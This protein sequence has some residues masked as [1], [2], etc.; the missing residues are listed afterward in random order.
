MEICG[1]TATQY[2]EREKCII[3][4]SPESGER[5]LQYSGDACLYREQA[6]TLC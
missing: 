6:D 3:S 4:L 2:G 1:E 5:K